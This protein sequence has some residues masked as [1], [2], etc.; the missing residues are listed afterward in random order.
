MRDKDG[1]LY[2]AF[3]SQETPAWSMLLFSPFVTGTLVPFGLDSLD[4]HSPI[5]HHFIS[6][7]LYRIPRKM[8]L[9]MLIVCRGSFTGNYI[10]VGELFRCTTWFN[11]Q[12]WPGVYALFLEVTYNF[13]LLSCMGTQYTFQAVKTLM[14]D[15]G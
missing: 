11:E 6:I 3:L 13:L 2:F 10:I 12:P 15:D 5:T 1:S 14:L 4:S 9:N 7:V 8:I